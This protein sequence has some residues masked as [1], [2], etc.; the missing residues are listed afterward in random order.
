MPNQASAGQ[1]GS[2]H[3]A[4]DRTKPRR[5]ELGNLPAVSLR[6][7]KQVRRIVV[8]ID[9][10]GELSV[11]WCWV[12]DV[13]DGNNVVMT[14]YRETETKAI[15]GETVRQSPRILAAALDLADRAEDYLSQ[16]NP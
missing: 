6:R 14:G 11:S 9:E 1:P 10:D 12:T 8:E 5:L 3:Q 13:V 7:I 2:E 16:P 15:K 4:G